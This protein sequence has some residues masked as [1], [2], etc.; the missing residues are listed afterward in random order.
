LGNGS[1]IRIVDIQC[2]G[3]RRAAS[4]ALHKEHIA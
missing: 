4:K 3:G 2:C 1:G